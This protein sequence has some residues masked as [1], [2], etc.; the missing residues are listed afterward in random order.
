MCAEGAGEGK[1]TRA[2][3]ADEVDDN[4]R[5]RELLK[6]TRLSG[7]VTTIHQPAEQGRNKRV[8]TGFAQW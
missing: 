8:E 5:S 1:D 4:D 2:T 7:L 6:K 3:A